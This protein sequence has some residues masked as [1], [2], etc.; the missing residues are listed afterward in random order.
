MTTTIVK[1]RDRASRDR[2]IEEIADEIGLT[3]YNMSF[4]YE[5]RAVLALIER[6]Y[7]IVPREGAE[8]LM[9]VAM[10][11]RVK[12]P[13]ANITSLEPVLTGSLGDAW[14]HIARAAIAALI[15]HYGRTH[16][17]P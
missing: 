4:K 7:V 11:E 10:K 17:A 9:A 2:L 14:P 12:R 15:E 13:L 16:G 6:E 3:R 8:E 1:E 5:A